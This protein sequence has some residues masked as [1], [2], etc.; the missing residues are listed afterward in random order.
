VNSHLPKPEEIP[1]RSRNR[2]RRSC[3]PRIRA[4]RRQSAARNA[5]RGG[6]PH[7]GA[8]RSKC[9]RVHSSPAAHI[10]RRSRSKSQST[11]EIRF[12][13]LLKSGRARHGRR[14]PGR[15]AGS[16]CTRSERP[17]ARTGRTES[18]GIGAG[19]HRN[20]LRDARQLQ[21]S[22]RRDTPTK[23]LY[24]SCLMLSS[25]SWCSPELLLTSSISRCLRPDS[26][27]RIIPGVEPQITM[28]DGIATARSGAFVASWYM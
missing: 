16:G 20:S 6:C 21:W 28:P 2:S 13:A 1:P 15:A 12:R 8:H 9:G 14:S 18:C 19:P 17:S 4:S 27:V 26:R 5:R 10:R 23:L 22:G 25:P 3:T 7:G 11:T 24:P